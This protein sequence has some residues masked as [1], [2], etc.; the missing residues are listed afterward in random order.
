MTEMTEEN[1]F[2][3]F[4]RDFVGQDA[5]MAQMSRKLGISHTRLIYW[6]QSPTVTNFFTAAK[7]M[8]VDLTIV[9]K[10]QDNYFIAVAERGDKKHTYQI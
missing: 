6:A 4:I 8:D 7:L 3:K 9:R 1:Q 2:L 5:T 10:T